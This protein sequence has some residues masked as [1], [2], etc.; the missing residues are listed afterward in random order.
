MQNAKLSLIREVL[1]RNSNPNFLIEGEIS[2]LQDRA[3]L[4]IRSFWRWEHS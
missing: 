1:K 3:S 4:T 2:D